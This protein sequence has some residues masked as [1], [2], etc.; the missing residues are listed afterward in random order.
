[1]AEVNDKLAEPVNLAEL[2]NFE[3]TRAPLLYATQFQ[4]SLTEVDVM[5]IA[6]RPHPARADGI[7]SGLA[8]VEDVAVIAMGFHALKNLSLV[9]PELVAQIE[10]RNGEIVTE[11]M[12]S[13]AAEK[14]VKK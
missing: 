8:K 13:R 5:L 3:M 6:Q 4:V 9:L 7:E 1:M 2:K 10:S 14:A 12:R 11:M